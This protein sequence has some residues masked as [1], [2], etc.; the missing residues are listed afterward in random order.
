MGDL[1]VYDGSIVEPNLA[2]VIRIQVSV[3]FVTLATI[4]LRVLVLVSLS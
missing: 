1:R 3:A 2:I 4:V